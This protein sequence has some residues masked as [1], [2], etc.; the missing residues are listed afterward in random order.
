V[1]WTGD[2]PQMAKVQSFAWNAAERAAASGGTEAD[3]HLQA[4]PTQGELLF[5]EYEKKKEKVSD[6]QKGSILDRYG[7]AEHLQAPPKELL[8]A[9][10]ENY[11]EYSQAGKV[12]R[13]QEKAKVKSKYEEDM[14][15]LNLFFL[16]YNFMCSLYI[17][18]FFSFLL[19][20]TSV[21]GSYWSGGQWGFACCHSFIRSSYCTGKAG[22]EA[23]AA[24]ARLMRDQM[25]SS[26]SSSSIEQTN[27][28]TQKTLLETHVLN[29]AKSLKAGGSLSTSESSKNSALEKGKARLGEGSVVIDKKKLKKAL[30]AEELRKKREIEDAGE[31]GKGKRKFNSME[32]D[33]EVTEEQLEAYRMAKS[34]YLDPMANFKDED[35][36]I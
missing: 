13:G 27:A 24:S 26:S 1:R 21:W 2:A 16:F 35:E 25:N 18:F 34:S 36:D 33:T 6:T 5:R 28:P 19:N 14:F 7:G 9:Q 32:N 4:N 10:T 23:A 3:I 30:E 31:E 8:L 15:V 20:H 11:V 29:A 22:I 12:I 17:W